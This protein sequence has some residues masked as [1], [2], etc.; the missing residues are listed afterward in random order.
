M[1]KCLILS[2]V[3]M[4]LLFW[5]LPSAVTLQSNPASALPWLPATDSQRWIYARLLL[6]FAAIAAG[7]TIIVKVGLY[8]WR[9][10]AD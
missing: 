10:I 9:E 8:L 6:E 2:I 4:V 5:A 3:L 1:K 7:L